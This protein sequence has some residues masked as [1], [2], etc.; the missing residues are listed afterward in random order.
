MKG[1]KLGSIKLKLV[2]FF[3]I[4]ILSSSTI[5]G[6][7][8]LEQARSSLREEAEKSLVIL[9][10]DAAKLTDSRTKIQV[11]VLK[12]IAST[13]GVDSMDWQIQ[14]PIL[15]K[16]LKETNFLD[17]AVVYPDGN[18]YYT[19]GTVSQLGDRS[20]IIKAFNGI[21]NVSDAIISR[22]TNSVILMQAV[23]IQKDGRVVGVLIGRS[24]GNLLSNI[25]DDVGFGNNGY[26]YIINSSGTIVGH[27]DRDMVMDQ[28]NPIEASKIDEGMKSTANLF[29]KVLKEKQGISSYIYNGN[30]MYVGYSPIEGSDWIFVITADENEVLSA[31]PKMENIIYNFLY[32]S[33][34]VSIVLV[35]IL[36]T[37]ITRPIIKSIQ[38]SKK[39]ADLNL[40][41]DIPKKYRRKKDEVG[42]LANALQTI[43]H[44]LRDIIAKITDTSSHVLRASEEISEAS[45]QSSSASFE[46]TNAIEEI[47]KSSSDQAYSTQQGAVSANELGTVIEEDQRYMSSLNFQTKKVINVVSEGLN[48]INVLYNITEESNNANNEINDVIIQTNDSSIKIGQASNVISSIAQQTNLLALNAAIEAARAGNAGKGFAVVAEEIKNLALQSSKSTKEIDEIVIELQSNSQNAVKTMERISSIVNEQ[49]KSVINS[50][51]KYQ[52]IANSM[53]DSEL[54]VNSMNTSGEKMDLMKNQILMNM[55]NLSSIAEEN[56]AATE[57]TTASI[58]EQAA[59]AEQI[60][61]T[62]QNLADLAN[63]MQKLILMFKL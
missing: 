6:L 40:I 28:Y 46:M 35:Y 41:E 29:E 22:V 34:A 12:M 21:A 48:E 63:D 2:L 5:I 33:L 62:S 3:S 26:G 15:Y 51:E 61:A 19:D 4:L 8:S 53:K 13:P 55:E 31:I 47:A 37:Y 39:I 9:A 18:A 59:L 24:D 49:T 42:E 30:S 7:I 11:E 57:Q 32:I 58:E 54:I 27:P 44:S 56:A 50:K 20:Y 1:I 38:Y 36:G 25:S 52:L 23:P 17:I 10:D 43:I 14:K 60:S 16:Q 45:K